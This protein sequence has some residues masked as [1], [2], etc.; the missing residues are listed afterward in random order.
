MLLGG[1]NGHR[2]ADEGWGR[3]DRPVI[4]VSWQD[5]QSYVSWLSRETGEDYRLPS[6]AEW[7]YAARAGSTTKYS[8]G[9]EIGRN[10]ANCER[11]RCGDS[12][13]NTAPVGSFGANA[14]GLHEMHGNVWE[15][16]EDCWNSSYEGAPSN[17]SAWLRGKCEERVVRG[18]S[19][20]NAPRLLRSAMR[21][22]GNAG[23]RDYSGV[24]FRVALTRTP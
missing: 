24:G 8:W 4:N 14:F 3:G 1:C 18:G 7:E 21:Y 10:R 20:D 16:V 9:N 19:W 2:P 5:A 15:W 23:D 17:G 22:R 11:G 13:R 6:E 12:Y